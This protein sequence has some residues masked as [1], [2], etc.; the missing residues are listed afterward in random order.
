[1]SS[2]FLRLNY[3][4]LSQRSCVPLETLCF[5][6]TITIRSKQPQHAWYV[7]FMTKSYQL[8]FIVLGMLITACF[9]IVLQFI[10]DCLK[11]AS[12]E[13][14][15]KICF[16]TK[17]CCFNFVVLGIAYNLDPIKPV[18]LN[19]SK[20]YFCLHASS[21]EAINPSMPDIWLHCSWYAH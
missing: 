16:L 8:D 4:Q 21:S 17:T 14:T 12:M 2:P 3:S 9:N 5:A 20:K 1:M 18:M 6:A 15:S 13:S 7:N 19:W 11:Y 10:L